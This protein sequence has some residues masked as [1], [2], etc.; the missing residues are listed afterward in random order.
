MAGF[1]FTCDPPRARLRLSGE[2][3]L[4][5]REQLGDVLVCLTLAGCRRVEIDLAAVTFIDAGTLRVLSDEQR[6]LAGCGGALE[7]VV[8]SDAALQLCSLAG[9]PGLAPSGSP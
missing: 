6:R 2:L 8:A 5:T 9:Y 1:Q 4:S 7:V 3:D